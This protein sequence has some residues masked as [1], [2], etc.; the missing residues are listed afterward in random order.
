MI[1]TPDRIRSTGITRCDGGLHLLHHVCRRRSVQQRNS[2]RKAVDKGTRRVQP[3]HG[4]EHTVG[5]KQSRAKNAPHQ[6]T[7]Y[8]HKDTEQP[9]MESHLAEAMGAAGNAHAYGSTARAASQHR[10]QVM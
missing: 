9:D 10:H 2:Y 1:L 4:N 7:K 6:D 5:H 8:V 3:G